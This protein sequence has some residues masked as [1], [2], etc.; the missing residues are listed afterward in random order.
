MSNSIIPLN[1]FTTW[2][3]KILPSKMK[4]N[5]E[6][7]KKQN[8]EFDVYLFDDNDC[9]NFIKN[10]FDESVVDAFNTLIPGA[11]KAD[12]WRYCI[13][14][15]YGGVYLDIKYRCADKFKLIELTD[16][17]YFVTDRPEKSIYNGFMVSL[18]KNEIL[19]KS[20]NQIIVNVKT[21]YYGLNPICPTGPTLIGSYFSDDFYKTNKLKFYQTRTKYEINDMIL[22]NNNI[23]L[24]NY[25]EYRIE[26]IKFQKTEHYD[27]LWHKKSIY[28]IVIKI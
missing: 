2:H 26:Q 20:I 15:V 7:L 23:I 8:P 18:P 19:L 9:T 27:T 14:Y 25:P 24:E 4:E 28:K 3:T 5:V 6:L 16:K 22:F 1:L 13:L 21:N 10:N 11:Y 12:L 17:E